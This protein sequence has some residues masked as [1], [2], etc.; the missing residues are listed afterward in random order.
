MSRRMW[1]VI[2]GVTSAAAFIAFGGVTKT[3]KFILA[4][5]K[6]Y[7]NGQLSI[8]REKKFLDFSGLHKTDGYYVRYYENGQKEAEG[9]AIESRPDGIRREWGP[10]GRLLDQWTFR[11]GIPADG[12]RVIYYPSGKKKEEIEYRDGT[13][14]GTWTKWSEDGKI[15]DSWKYVDGDPVDGTRTIFYSSGLPRERRTYKNGKFE[16][17][18]TFWDEDGKKMQEQYYRNG[19][20]TGLT[21]FDKSGKIKNRVE[22]DR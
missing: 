10:D 7:S 14:N 9:H 17:I 4:E 19:K 11:N 15:L 16:G 13:N 1:I 2:V 8:Y 18:E 21:D 22:Y 12:T 5:R 3:V 6:Y 20:Q